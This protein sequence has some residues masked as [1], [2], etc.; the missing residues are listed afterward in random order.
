MPDAANIAVALAKDSNLRI[1]VLDAD[2]FGPSQPRLF[3]L[4]GRP[5]ASEGAQL[6]VA[7]HE[8]SQLSVCASQAQSGLNVYKVFI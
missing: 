2:V 4:K 7:L 1:G 8:Q 3:G 5:E 6:S